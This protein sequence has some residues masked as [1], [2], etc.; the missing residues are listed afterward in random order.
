MIGAGAT[1]AKETSRW[2]ERDGVAHAAVGDAGAAMRAV[3][4]PNAG[5]GR[6]PGAQ[7]RTTAAMK[8][9]I[10]GALDRVGGESYLAEIAR[11]DHKTFCA[12]LGNSCRATSRTKPR[13]RS[14]CRSVNSGISL[15]R[16]GRRQIPSSK[17]GSASTR[18]KSFVGHVAHRQT[19][20]LLRGTY[21]CSP[22]QDPSPSRR[23]PPVRA[24]R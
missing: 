11:K 21:P 9:A 2:L 4:P 3:K 24:R 20:D 16:D 10:L 15:P 14:W 17:P 1:E 12:L 6:K 7:N 8:D 19:D 13:A 5:M 23:P 22:K 18:K